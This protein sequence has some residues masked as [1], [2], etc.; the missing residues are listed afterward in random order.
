MKNTS[1][2]LLS[3]I[4]LLSSCIN[5]EAPLET[6]DRSVYKE[7]FDN[8]IDI[9]N[10]SLGYVQLLQKCLTLDELQFS[11]IQKIV[12]DFREKR[13]DGTEAE[14]LQLKKERTLAIKQI[15]DKTQ[16]SQKLFVDA[17][18]NNLKIG[19][20]NKMHPINIQ[21]KLDI[22]DGQLLKL[23]EI[24]EFYRKERKISEANIRVTNIIGQEKAKI[25]RHMNFL[26]Q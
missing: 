2:F 19:K 26:K 3:L 22:S 9:T 4:I 10:T 5:K 14:I 13:K 7:T 6:I 1:T 18:V 8:T 16:L 25:T 12:Q 15:L 21:K 11:K 24:R 17:K 23:L 20:K